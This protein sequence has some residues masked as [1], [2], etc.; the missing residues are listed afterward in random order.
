MMDY[1]NNDTEKECRKSSVEEVAEAASL[2]ERIIGPGYFKKQVELLKENDPLG[3]GMGRY[4][5]PPSVSPLAYIWLKAREELIYGEIAGGFRSG[6]AS[7]RLRELGKD[8]APLQHLKELRR[9]IGLLTREETFELA[10]LA[11]HVAAGCRKEDLP[12]EF[13]PDQGVNLTC[14]VIHDEEAAGVY[15]SI[16]D[17]AAQAAAGGIEQAFPVITKEMPQPALLYVGIIA[18]GE[19]NP[20]DGYLVRTAQQWLEG[21][22]ETAAAAVLCQGRLNTGKKGLTFFRKSYVLRNPSRNKFHS[23]L[24]A[25]IYVPS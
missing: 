9:M 10:A 17:A 21:P 1:F 14:M 16:W 22:G 25:N 6:Y 5:R 23:R 12:G 18:D 24:N 8:I 11:L 20:E 13:C 15:C 4:G 7:A 3:A 2:L 19:V